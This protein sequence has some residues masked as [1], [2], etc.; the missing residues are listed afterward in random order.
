MGNVPS[1]SSTNVLIAQMFCSYV[2]YTAHELFL[3]ELSLCEL[4]SYG[5]CSSD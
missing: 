4:L 5:L 1:P 3:C 2:D